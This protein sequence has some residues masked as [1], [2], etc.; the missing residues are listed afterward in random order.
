ASLDRLAVRLRLG[1]GSRADDIVA[2][3]AKESGLPGSRLRRL[4]FPEKIT[5][6]AGLVEWAQELHTV[7]K[8]IGIP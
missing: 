2:T 8:E 6:E 3:A 7:E 5:G 4:Y 1:H